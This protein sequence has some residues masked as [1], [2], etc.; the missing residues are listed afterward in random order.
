MLSIFLIPG[1]L[2]CNWAGIPAS[3]DHRMILRSFINT[4]VWSGV[5]IAAALWISL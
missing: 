5:A 3:S 4:M 2:V 1:D